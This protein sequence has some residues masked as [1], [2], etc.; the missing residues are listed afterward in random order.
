MES[1]LW[2]RCASG[3][4]LTKKSLFFNIDFIDTSCGSALTGILIH[5]L[6][7]GGYWLRFDWNILLDLVVLFNSLLRRDDWRSRGGRRGT[8]TFYRGC[9]GIGV[10]RRC[11]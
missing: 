8:W 2:V 6:L 3:N 1:I 9:A 7:L 5:L 10:G 4:V 11:V